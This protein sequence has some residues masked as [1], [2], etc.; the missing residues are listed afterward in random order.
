VV[1]LQEDAAAGVFGVPPVVAGRVGKVE[2]LLDDPAVELHGDELGVG[3]SVSHS[4][5]GLR[6]LMRGG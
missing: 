4:P 2:V 1:A 5:K 6:A 3:A